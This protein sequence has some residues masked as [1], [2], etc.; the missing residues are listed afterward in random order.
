MSIKI[1]ISQLTHENIDFLE[2]SYIQQ[3]T[4]KN[5]KHYIKQEKIHSLK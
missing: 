1:P 5:N 4:D 3:D 2:N